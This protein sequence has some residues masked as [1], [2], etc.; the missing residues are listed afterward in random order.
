MQRITRFA[1]LTSLVAFWRCRARVSIGVSAALLVTGPAYAA[2]RTNDAGLLTTDV[3]C[4]AHKSDRR[5]G[6]RYRYDV[7][8]S[9]LR[10]S[11]RRFK[12]S[13]RAT[14]KYG[15]DQGCDIG[16]DSLKQEADDDTILLRTTTANS[17]EKPGCTIRIVA[18]RK[19]IRIQIGDAAEQG[20]DCRGSDGEMY[21]SPRSFWADMIVDRKTAACRPV[22]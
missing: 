7:T 14:S 19:Q 1:R 9:V 8:L 6:Y 21:C 10:G 11:V 15:D 4:T 13:Q 5:F 2:P 12:L 22:E 16:L 17:L 3:V 18:D 20:N